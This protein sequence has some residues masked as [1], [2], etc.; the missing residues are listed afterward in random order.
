M[1]APVRPEEFVRWFRQAAPYL[2]AFGGRT[3]VIGFGG[4]LITER[5]RFAQFI[6]DLNLLAALDIRLVLVHGARPQIE[7]EL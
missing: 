3:F 4:E 5:A 2:H 6:Q 7:A 1:T